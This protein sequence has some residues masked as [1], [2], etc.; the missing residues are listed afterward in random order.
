[1]EAKKLVHPIKLRRWKEVT[2]LHQ[3]V[4]MQERIPIQLAVEPTSFSALILSLRGKAHMK[5]LHIQ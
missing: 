2:S 1:M 3:L 5:Y 4:N